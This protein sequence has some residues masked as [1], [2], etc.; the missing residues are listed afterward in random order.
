M[1]GAGYAA[2]LRRITAELTNLGLKFSCELCTL[3]RSAL[4]ESSERIVSDV[5]SSRAITS[6]SVARRFYEV[7]KTCDEF[8][9]INC[10][11]TLSPD[12]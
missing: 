10:H 4:E 1:E 11:V 8:L 3:I 9:S 5:F 7:I 6:L 2:A 12:D